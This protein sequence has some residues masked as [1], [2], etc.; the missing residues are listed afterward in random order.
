MRYR[1]GPWSAL[2]DGG[3]ARP[4]DDAEVT[5]MEIGH[6]DHAENHEVLSLRFPA[7]EPGFDSADD[8]A[9]LYWERDESGEHGLS[10][11]DAVGVT[12]GD[13]GEPTT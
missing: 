3:G 4:V 10:G 5:T 7:S 9:W 8:V 2:S 12:E 13:G 11:F 1:F 6:G